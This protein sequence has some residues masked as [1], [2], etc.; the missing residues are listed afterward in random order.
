MTSFWSLLHREELDQLNKENELLSA[1]AER[2]TVE[3]RES[4]RRRNRVERVLSDAAA[5][6]KMVLTVST[7][8]Y[9]MSSALWC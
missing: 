1:D 5:S 6:I 2:L 8:F 4:K 7:F 9:M 3:A